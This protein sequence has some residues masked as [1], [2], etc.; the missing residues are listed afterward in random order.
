MRVLLYCRCFQYTKP[1]YV[2]KILPVF[3][4]RHPQGFIMDPSE[5][6]ENLN[7]GVDAVVLNDGSDHD[8]SSGQKDTTASDMLRFIY[9][10]CNNILCLFLFF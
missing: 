2:I 3:L 5:D 6:V 9:N 8:T 4:L 1:G 7:Q 10:S